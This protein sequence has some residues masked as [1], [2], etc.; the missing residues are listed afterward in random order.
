MHRKIRVVLSRIAVLPRVLLVFDP[1]RGELH[2]CRFSGGYL[3]VTW[4]LLGGS[5]RGILGDV[6]SNSLFGG[7]P[8]Y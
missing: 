5:G 7:W 4:R 2:G 8:S 3:V 6:S 1:P